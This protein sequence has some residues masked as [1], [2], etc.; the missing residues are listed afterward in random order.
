MQPA[1]VATAAPNPKRALV[2][3][4]SN[5]LGPGVADNMNVIIA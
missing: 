4:T 1:I 5:M 2:L 3:M